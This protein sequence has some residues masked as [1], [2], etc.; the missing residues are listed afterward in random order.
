MIRV[1]NSSRLDFIPQH[2]LQTVLKHLLCLD[3]YSMNA[4]YCGYLN[5]RDQQLLFTC[6]KAFLILFHLLVFV[7]EAF[8]LGFTLFLG[9][10]LSLVIWGVE[11][12]ESVNL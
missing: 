3:Y 12:Q 4:Q 9:E 5:L 1:T 8:I 2:H 10:Q 6:F 11:P 7:D